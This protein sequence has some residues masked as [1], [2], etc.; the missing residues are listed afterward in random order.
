[1]LRAAGFWLYPS[2]VIAALSRSSTAGEK[3]CWRFMYF[4]TVAIDTPAAAATSRM[5]AILRAVMGKRLPSACDI[6]LYC[7]CTNSPC[8][9]IDEA[10]AR[11]DQGKAGCGNCH[12]CCCGSVS[13]IFPIFQFIKAFLEDQAIASGFLPER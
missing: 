1:M 4:D 11:Q 2:S 10:I 13:F 8:K 6:S 12:R 7:T 9:T 3:L 5:V